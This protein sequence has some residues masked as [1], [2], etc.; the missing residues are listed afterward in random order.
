MECIFGGQQR[1][2]VELRAFIGTLDCL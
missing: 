2:K 1:N